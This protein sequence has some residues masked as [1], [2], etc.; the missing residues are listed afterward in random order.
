VM[1]CSCY[2]VVNGFNIGSIITAVIGAVVLL[3]IL[4]AVR[5]A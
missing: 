5:R 4:R 3:A 1:P 2:L